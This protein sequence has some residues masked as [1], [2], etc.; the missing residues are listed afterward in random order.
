[1]QHWHHRLAV[2]QAPLKVIAG[3][4]E[5][6]SG[7][8]VRGRAHDGQAAPA[9]AHSVARANTRHMM[10]DA[11]SEFQIAARRARRRLGAGRS[12]ARALGASLFAPLAARAPRGYNCE[13][14]EIPRPHA[15]FGFLMS[16]VAR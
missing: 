15:V 14:T 3:T 2:K 5:R 13:Y 11:G 1:M 16:A 10:R 12:A 7:P 4:L 8:A 6:E 9:P